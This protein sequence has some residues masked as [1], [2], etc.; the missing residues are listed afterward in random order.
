VFPTFDVNYTDYIT[1]LPNAGYVRLDDIT[2]TAFNKFIIAMK[3]ITV[4]DKCPQKG[5][6]ADPFD[7]NVMPKLSC[8]GGD[9]SGASASFGGKKRKTYKKYKKTQYKK[10]KKTKNHRKRRC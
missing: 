3:L 5:E 9:S 6:M 8:F 4:N 1:E 7:N 10:Y 2:A